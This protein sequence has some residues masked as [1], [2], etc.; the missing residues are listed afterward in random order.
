MSTGRDSVDRRPS[1]AGGS[2][3]SPSLDANAVAAADPRDNASPQPTPVTPPPQR[4]AAGD[5]GGEGADAATAANA[6]RRLTRDDFEA[7]IKDALLRIDERLAREDSEPPNEAAQ[8]LIRRDREGSDGEDG[9]GG[10]GNR[11]IL[12]LPTAPAAAEPH[13]QPIS[14]APTPAPTP[15]PTP[16]SRRY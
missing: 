14:H 7:A 11:G 2:A 5:A 4:D 3:S 6:Q 15:L 1:H 13:Q 8:L 9:N 12:V 10:G 16:S